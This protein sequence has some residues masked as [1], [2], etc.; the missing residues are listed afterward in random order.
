[1]IGTILDFNSY[2]TPEG[3]PA[4]IGRE[5]VATLWSAL[6]VQKEADRILLTRY[7]PVGVVIDETMT[8][9]QFRGRTS[10]Y[11]EPAPGMATLDLFR[12]LRE[13][14]MAEVRSAANQAKAENTPVVRE[15]LRLLDGEQSRLIKI[16]VLPFKV[17]PAAVRFFLILFQDV[18]L[19]EPS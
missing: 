6:D 19:G 5:E 8:V 2:V 4:R 11:L 18:A 14:L 17:S 16:E 13:G 10:A 3:R 12:M 1:S 9:L 7:A 15:G